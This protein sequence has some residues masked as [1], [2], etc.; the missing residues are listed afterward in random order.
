[1]W[2]YW[3]S[4][5]IPFGAEAIAYV[6]ALDIDSDVAVA[7]QAGLSEASCA[8]LR[9][10]TMLLKAALLG[11]GRAAPKP[12]P[13]SQPEPEPAPEP[14]PEVAG[15]AKG[16]AK[17]SAKGIT[18]G[19]AAG[20]AAGA[21][22]TGS[23]GGGG[24]VTPKALAGMLMRE[25]YDEPSPF[26]R[27]CANPNPNP[28]PNRSPSPNLNPYPSPTPNQVRPGAGCVRRGG[29][30]RHSAHRLRRGPYTRGRRGLCAAAR[31]LRPLRAPPRGDLR[32]APR[33]YAAVALPLGGGTR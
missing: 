19:V 20:V 32:R 18:A 16:L 31:V 24:G 22:A 8:T 9:T 17:G 25:S 23:G 11:G 13:E 6:A 1:M 7:R 33:R 12:K 30:P 27:L 4:S 14:A 5:N 15:V 10:C 3:L 2:R 28:N 26:E 29:G 21:A